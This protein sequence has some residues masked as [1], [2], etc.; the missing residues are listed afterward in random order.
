M[1]EET[2]SMLNMNLVWLYLIKGLI[3]VPFSVVATM[4]S[5]GTFSVWDHFS[6][7]YD[8]RAELKIWL[9]CAIILGMFIMFGL[10][11]GG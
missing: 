5:L 9:E 11:I 7:K 10:I 1:I 2:Q 4:L 3:A 6:K 8:K